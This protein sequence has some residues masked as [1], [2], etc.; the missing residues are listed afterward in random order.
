MNYYNEW[1]KYAVAWLR[2]L[3]AEKL[4]PPGEVD[5]RSIADV[6]PT[7]IA[8]YTQCHFFA[9][10][11]GWSLAFKLAG[12]P[13]NRPAWSGS[14]PCQPYSVAGKQ[15]GHDDE[16][17]LWHHQLRLINAL[18]PVVFVGEQVAA[19]ISKD[20]LD[21]M[22]FDLSSLGYACD[23]AVIPA[24]AVNAPHRRD[25]I[26][27]IAE[28]GG[29]ALDHG[30]GAGLEGFAWD[31]STTEGWSQPDRSAATAC[32]GS[33]LADSD[34]GTGRQGYSIDARSNHGSG[35]HVGTGPHGS[36]AGSSGIVA[37][38][39]LISASEERST[40]SRELGRTGGDSWACDSWIIGHDGKA[41]RVE[42]GIR[43]L[44]HGVPARVGK[45]RAYGNA[46]VPQVAAEVISAYME[47][48][49]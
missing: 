34:I 9:G 36:S 12:W 15:L 33:M 5:D 49:P 41:R 6:S 48:R 16:R 21:R 2:N 8:G 39:N 3:I 27:A 19:A 46:I 23:G 47:C 18:R 7:D 42:P 13:D 22:F 17:D 31:G 35:A 14:L 11:G 40:R 4:L 32:R 43:L 29:G 24:C 20:W 1:D 25:R 10:I 44:A 28:L 26:F 45:L 37:D 30:I 38:G